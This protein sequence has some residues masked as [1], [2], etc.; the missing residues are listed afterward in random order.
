MDDH[1]MYIKIQRLIYLVTSY[2]MFPSNIIAHACIPTPKDE[3]YWIM[4]WSCS[5][6]WCSP[7]F[8]LIWKSWFFSFM[9]K[10]LIVE[11]S[12]SSLLTRNM[13]MDIK[14]DSNFKYCK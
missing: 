6:K 12:H 2:E 4:W 10:L 1:N 14:Q 5:L 3:E 7:Q 9:K 11:T 8:E 13:Q